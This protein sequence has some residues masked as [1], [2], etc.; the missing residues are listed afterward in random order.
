ITDKELKSAAGFNEVIDKFMRWCGDDCIFSSWSNTDLYVMLENMGAYKNLN[1]IPF[2]KK[3]FDMQKY[4]TRELHKTDNN[5]ISLKSAAESFSICTDNFSLHRAEDDSRVC[6]ELFRKTYSERVLKG[7]I[8]DTSAPEYYARM[9]F[10]PY[11][12]TDLAKYEI[13][14]RTF[15]CACP[16][17]RKRMRKISKTTQKFSVFNTKMLCLCCKRSFDLQVKIKKTY[18]GFDIKKKL[19]EQTADKPQSTQTDEST[20]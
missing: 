6:A 1:S 17:C 19:R 13:P 3:Y 5:Q 16:Y 14:S 15:S 8:T 9:A 2:I 12:I 20:T 10:K 11:Y 4:V 7:Y 18:D